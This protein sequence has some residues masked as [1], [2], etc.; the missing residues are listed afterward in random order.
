MKK[1]ALVTYQK[2]PNLSNDDRLLLNHLQHNDIAAQAVI[3]D[4][5]DVAWNSFDAI[6]LRSCWDYHLRPEEFLNWIKRLEMNGAPLWNLPRVVK[7]NMDKTYLR[8]LET[9]GISIAPSVWV[10][11]G[12]PANLKKILEARGW[13]KAVV[14][15]TL[16]ASAYQTWVTTLENAESDQAKLDEMLNRS[17]VLIQKFVDEIQ[18]KGEWSFIF[19]GGKYS[20]AVLKL[21][22]NG[23]FRVQEEHGG[24]SEARTPDQTL[25]KQ[26]Q[27]IVESVDK[28]LLYARVDAVEMNGKLTLMELE[29]I[30]PVLFLA[31]DPLAPRRFAEA[32]IA[33]VVM[34]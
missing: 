32:I 14:K 29:L 2:L 19:F 15:P 11:K 22:K 23:D 30:E 27:R 18:V 5:P 24:F 1:L 10:E 12:A 17:G 4:A 7:W 25:I 31:H 9:Q 16:S 3:W 34:P 13:E 28:P 8:M 20:H 6:I 21:P 33:S 26:A